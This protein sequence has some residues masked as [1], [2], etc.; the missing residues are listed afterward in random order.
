MFYSFDYHYDYDYCPDWDC[1][2]DENCLLSLSA[3]S[4]QISSTVYSYNNGG[5]YAVTLQGPTYEHASS[6]F[7]QIVIYMLDGG[8]ISGS[9]YAD[10]S[11]GT[12]SITYNIGSDA[13]NNI[14]WENFYITATT[15]YCNNP[16]HCYL[17]G[18]VVNNSIETV[19][20][21]CGFTD[22]ECSIY[23]AYYEQISLLT[24]G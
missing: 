8:T 1:S 9:G 11:N 22:E 23:K 24:G 6:L 10:V 13:Y 18:E 12:W 16:N 5:N 7:T 17:Y 15:V 3:G 14:D 2:I 20:H 4:F 21:K 19:M